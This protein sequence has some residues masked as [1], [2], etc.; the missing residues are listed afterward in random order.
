MEEFSQK[1]FETEDRR[2][3]IFLRADGVFTY[4]IQFK[5]NGE[6][7]GLGPICGFYDS[8]ETA[9]SELRA[10]VPWMHFAITC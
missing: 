4:R 10:R 3:H 9:E 2:A 8:L 1:S 5:E 6:W 7:G